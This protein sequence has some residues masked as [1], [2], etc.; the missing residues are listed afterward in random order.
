MKTR[1]FFTHTFPFQSAGVF[2]L[3]LSYE[4]IPRMWMLDAD[5]FF[6]SV[7]TVTSSQVYLK[8][9]NY[10]LMWQSTVISANQ[11][12]KKVR[13]VKWTS[14]IH[15]CSW[16]RDYCID[17]QGEIYERKVLAGILLKITTTITVV[18]IW[19]VHLYRY[20]TLDVFF[21]FLDTVRNSS[22]RYSYSQCEAVVSGITYA[23]VR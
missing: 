20:T 7:F 22:G 23:A 5:L 9:D 14:I 3:S 1:H 11:M 16:D 13:S 12:L 2:F 10:P 21:F 19:Y 8:H 18:A 15:L 6:F 4:V 17:P